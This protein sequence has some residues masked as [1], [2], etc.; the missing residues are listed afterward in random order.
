MSSIVENASQIPATRA[1]RREPYLFWVFAIALAAI[2]GC[3]LLA[4]VYPDPVG[5]DAASM[6]GP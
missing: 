3:A 1:V 2:V 4:S 5:L 6:I